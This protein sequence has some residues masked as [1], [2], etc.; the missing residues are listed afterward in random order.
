LYSIR[1][2]SDQQ[3]KEKENKI[4][5]NSK[6]KVAQAFL[7]PTQQGT[8]HDIDGLAM[9]QS[10]PKASMAQP[11]LVA[12]PWPRWPDRPGLVW[13]PGHWAKKGHGVRVEP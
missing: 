8:A 13:Q 1:I 7:A 11:R 6:V 5:E 3:E 4:T 10:R 9:L 12:G 2:E